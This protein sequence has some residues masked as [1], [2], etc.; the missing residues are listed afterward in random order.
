[1]NACRISESDRA[2]QYASIGL[3]NHAWNDPTASR[4]IGVL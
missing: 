1:M 4:H 2:A 3:H